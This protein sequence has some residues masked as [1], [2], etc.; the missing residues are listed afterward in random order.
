MRIGSTSAKMSSTEFLSRIDLFQK[1]RN[2]RKLHTRN[3]P[4]TDNTNLGLIL[5]GTAYQ[6]RIPWPRQTIS[7]RFYPNWSKWGLC[8]FFCFSIEMAGHDKTPECFLKNRIFFYLFSLHLQE[9]FRQ[10]DIGIAF[11]QEKVVI[12]NCNKAPKVLSPLIS[13]MLFNA[14]LRFSSNNFCF[15]RNCRIS[16]TQSSSA[17]KAF[18]SFRPTLE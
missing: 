17:R 1:N 9:I 2:K 7:P 8:S 10:T 12:E 16:P 11:I 5:A 18:S 3:K 6:T 13:I 14:S 15:C 4:L